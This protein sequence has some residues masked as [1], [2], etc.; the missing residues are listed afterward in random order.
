MKRQTQIGA[1]SYGF[2]LVVT[3]TNASVSVRWFISAAIY[4]R[5]DEIMFIVFHQ[6]HKI[7]LNIKYK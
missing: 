4:A 1:L 5:F 2:H 7:N 6:E 3:Y